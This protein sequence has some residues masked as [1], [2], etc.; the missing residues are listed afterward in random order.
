MLRVTKLKGPR[1]ITLKLEGKLSHD[2]VPA[3]QESWTAA[4][5]ENNGCHLVIDLIGVSFVDEAGRKLLVRIDAAGAELVGAGP[6]MTSL[7]EEIAATRKKP[8]RRRALLIGLLLVLLL[9]TRLSAQTARP[10]LSL[11]E[12]ISIA[13]A[14]NRQVRIA[15]LETQ[16][17]VIQF[18]ISKLD[19]L[20]AIS[21]EIYASGLLTPLSFEFEKG[22]L[23]DIP[24]TGPI[25][26]ENTKITTD[27]S[28]NIV[29]TASVKQPLTQLYRINLGIK[30]RKLSA[31]AQREKERAERIAIAAKVRSTY[32]DIL[33]VES[34]LDAS[35]S[36]IAAYR[37]LNTLMDRYLVEQVA[38][39]S[40]ALEVRTKL[41]SEQQ[42][43]LSLRHSAEGAREQLNL[44]MGR[45]PATEFDVDRVGA[46][47][48][49]ELTLSQAR[50]RALEQ[51]PELRQIELELKQAEYAR[52]IK[53]SEYIPDV[54][55]YASY[56][57]PFNIR[58]V[59]QN[60]AS[61]GVQLTWEPFDWGRKR[62]EV[63]D[64]QLVIEQAENK[65]RETRDQI[66]VE[67]GVKLRK[68]QESNLMLQAA[69]LG[70]QTARE[71]LRVVTAKY[72][73]RAALVKDVLGEE[74]RL[75]EANHQYQEAL[76]GF[77]NAKSDLTKAMGEE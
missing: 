26:D 63:Q 40:E 1:A 7:L 16:R 25:P 43:A 69:E 6:M 67:V 68:L 41:I 74:S 37:E 4:A 13:L 9:A 61:A 72:G 45:D 48:F 55:L 12:A 11:D 27:P 64:R 77:W 8:R 32:Y 52:K 47:D 49:G 66:V 34:A 22:S 53:K 73:E 51:R 33:R 76:L 31:E 44:L 46:A 71:K 14:N 3:L 21:T 39:K 17:S 42:R 36:A 5:A 56:I 75:R 50:V 65:Y 35:E 2:W 28:F 60:I 62:R 29:A 38:L 30:A 23:G 20:P 15:E 54:G 70:Q 10:V 59:P 18:E 58:F 24:G 19:R 57:S